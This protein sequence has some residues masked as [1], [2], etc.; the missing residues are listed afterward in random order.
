MPIKYLLLSSMLL[1][2]NLVASQGD[3]VESKKAATKHEYRLH[4]LFAKL[5]EAL[6]LYII[7][8]AVTP[9][10]KVTTHQEPMTGS[11]AHR[12]LVPINTEFVPAC[13]ATVGQ[14]LGRDVLSGASRRVDVEPYD[15][16]VTKKVVQQF[17]K[18]LALQERKN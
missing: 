8:L 2:G 14:Y 10:H 16:S 9:L 6:G 18:D 3:Q 15:R 12:Y 13:R 17:Y 11:Y 5:P 4:E 7:N 1:A